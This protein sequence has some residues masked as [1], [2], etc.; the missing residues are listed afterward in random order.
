MNPTPTTSISVMVQSRGKNHTSHLNREN[1]IYVIITSKR[2]SATKRLKTAEIANIGSIAATFRA[3][4]KHLRREQIRKYLP[5]P[6][7]P[8]FIPLEVCVLRPLESG[9]PG[10]QGPEKQAG[11][12][13]P[14]VS[15]RLVG[16]RTGGVRGGQP[17]AAERPFRP[18]PC[19]SLQPLWTED[20]LLHVVHFSIVFS[21]SLIS[22]LTCITSIL[23]LWV[24][25]T[26]F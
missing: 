14:L 23:L 8:R 12:C 20:Q 11:E 7:R 5:H 2:Q 26:L 6:T 18:Q 24:S 13:A 1:V 22:T 10:C 15:C 9:A 16:A 25:F 4:E 17:T 3:E 21:V 19:R